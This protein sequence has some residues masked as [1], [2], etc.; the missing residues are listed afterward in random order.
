M[1]ILEPTTSTLTTLTAD[2]NAHFDQTHGKKV[3]AQILGANTGGL[4]V[5]TLIVTS[6]I[7]EVIEV[8]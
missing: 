2:Y 7:A 6:R 1:H 8:L 3:R 4:L 5:V